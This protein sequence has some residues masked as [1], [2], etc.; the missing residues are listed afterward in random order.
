[1]GDLTGNRVGKVDETL[2][3]LG[4]S[5]DPKGVYFAVEMGNG[6]WYIHWSEKL[7]IADPLR[8]AHYIYDAPRLMD[9]RRW[10]KDNRIVA[11]QRLR[12]SLGG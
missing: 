5:F 12:K 9:C 8:G 3:K 7:N 10:F 6:D 1:M 11:A 4:D 2:Y